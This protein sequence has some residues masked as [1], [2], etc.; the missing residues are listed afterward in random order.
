MA[1]HEVRGGLPVHLPERSFS[2][3]ATFSTKEST[4]DLF[5]ALIL[6]TLD[7]IYLLQN[8]YEIFYLV[9]MKIISFKLYST[10]IFVIM[11]Y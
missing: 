8:L 10:V 9:F 11:Y 5:V 7:Y 1:C 4:T 3:P 6:P 2:S